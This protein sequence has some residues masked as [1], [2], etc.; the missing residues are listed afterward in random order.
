[1]WETIKLDKHVHLRKLK[2]TREGDP[3]IVISYLLNV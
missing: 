3:Q 2:R 1:M